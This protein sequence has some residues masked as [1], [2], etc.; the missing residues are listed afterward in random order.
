MSEAAAAIDQFSRFIEKRGLFGD[1]EARWSALNGKTSTV[2][3]TETRTMLFGEA[4][5]QADYSLSSASDVD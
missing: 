1:R 3:L 2:R 5:W 4:R